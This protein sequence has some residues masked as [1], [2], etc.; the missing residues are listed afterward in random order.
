MR[1][2][3][4]SRTGVCVLR[5]ER[6]GAAGILITVTT[7]PD[8]SL[9]SPGQSR[10]VADAAAALCLVAGFLADYEHG[11]SAGTGTS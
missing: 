11:D 3:T 6:R 10:S 1:Q 7:A 9:R 5:V 2:T 4:P 8:I